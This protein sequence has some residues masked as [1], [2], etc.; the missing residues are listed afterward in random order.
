MIL[1]D[2][3]VWVEHLRKGKATLA[4]ALENGTV[5]MHPF[6]IGEIA[7]GNL[8]RRKALLRL[9]CDLPQALVA[10]DTE[11]LDFIERRSLMGRGIGYIDAHLLAAV[12]IDGSASL[13]SLDKRLDAIAREL[14]LA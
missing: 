3:S 14:N 10:T 12:A 6:V 4:G 13:W 11:V 9:L 1:V 8:T 2:T 7:C 5:L